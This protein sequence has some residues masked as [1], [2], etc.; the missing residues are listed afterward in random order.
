M[1]IYTNHAQRRMAQRNIQDDE[2]R[3]I[4]E[5]G[6]PIHKAGVIFFQMWQKRLSRRAK[7]N[8]HLSHLAGAT[9]V[10]CCNEAGEYLII[11]VYRDPRAFKRDRT[12]KEYNW[13]KTAHEWSNV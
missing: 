13:R 4:I 5:H 12:K 1:I 3:F 2:I 11:T 8:D 7:P 6:K 9:V 10:A